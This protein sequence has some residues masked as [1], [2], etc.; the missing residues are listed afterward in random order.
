[1]SKFEKIYHIDP[2]R[3][4]KQP[5]ELHTSIELSDEQYLD[6]FKPTEPKKE[7]KIITLHNESA[8]IPMHQEMPI[9]EEQIKKG[10]KDAKSKSKS[11]KRK[12]KKNPTKSNK[13]AM[14]SLQKKL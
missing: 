3:E 14:A 9:L 6:R 1:M 5:R 10:I 7:C 2:T 4:S 13:S 12:A 8:K 11:P